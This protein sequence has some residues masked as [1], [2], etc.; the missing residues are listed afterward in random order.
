MRT[1][2]GSADP[3]APRRF[4]GLA[5]FARSL[6]EALWKCAPFFGL[7]ALSFVLLKEVGQG[8][9][10]LAALLDLGP[11]NISWFLFA[12]LLG[13]S[14]L[15]T[16]S[17]L[18]LLL[19]RW[20]YAAADGSRAFCRIWVPS[21]LTLSASLVI[22]IAAERS[23]AHSKFFDVLLGFPICLLI[24]ALVGLAWSRTRPVFAPART[25]FI[26]V[27]GVSLLASF[28]IGLLAFYG[29]CFVFLTAFCFLIRDDFRDGNP[30]F[31]PWADLHPNG[32]FHATLLCLAVLWL[33]NTSV[34]NRM[35]V[36]TPMIV[37]CGFSFFAGL[38]YLLT[39]LLSRISPG[40]VWTGWGLLCLLL[41][42]TPVNHE[43]LRL[44]PRAPNP[45]RR[46][47][48]S[49]HFVEWLRSRPEVQ[50]GNRP[51]PVFFVA[52]EGGGIRAAYWTSTLL[53]SLEERYP[54]FTSHVYAISGVS[55]GSV[56]GAIY[57]AMFRDASGA[58]RCAP[59]VQGGLKGLRPCTA[60]L[61]Q[62]DLLGSPLSALLLHDLP[63][64]WLG[65]RRAHD[66]EQSLEIAWFADL[67]NRR[68]EE[69]FLDLWRDRTYQVPSLILNATSAD[70]GHRLVLSNLAARGELTAETGVE[71]LLDRPVRLST[72][73][74]LSARFPLLSPVATFET[75]AGKAYRLVDGGYFNNS[76]LAS[77]ARL[78]RAVIP[79]VAGSELAG[80]IEPHVLVISSRPAGPPAA[81][82]RLAGSFAGALVGPVAV[83]QSTGEA[84]DETYLGE[85]ERIV[86]AGGVATDL[87][88]IEGSS[89]APLG[90]FFSAATRC[91]LDR[92]VNEVTNQSKGSKAI[93]RALE[94]PARPPAAWTSCPPAPEP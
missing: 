29:F 1:Q 14:S 18:F 32:L 4:F 89:E 83:L 27:G 84:H 53:A 43:P 46:L 75:P 74:F 52:A 44:L 12:L 72:A 59:L 88:P 41:V 64:G 70:N 50:E 76:G 51:Y 6:V 56:G 77:L 33:S 25:I 24:P 45:T 21:V 38:A 49:A 73:A 61:F 86:G 30:N 11:A 54:G 48:P 26:L 8:R 22:P 67:E 90:W 65:V 62:W 2:W 78:L 40:A 91:Q 5:H 69:P 10:T 68:F 3:R 82:G 13:V 42:L 57:D 94:L 35:L 15:F 79:A 39:G 9:E 80:R 71:E 16:A 66:L 55:G 85:I 20:N 34:A 28:F 36:G 92:N 63:F 19:D 23:A 81:P 17:F 87:R 7:Y 37:L 58:K 31:R 93:A 47:A 60:Y